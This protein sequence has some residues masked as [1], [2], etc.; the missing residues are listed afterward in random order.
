MT[1]D[2]GEALHCFF[3]MKHGYLGECIS[4]LIAI[5]SISWVMRVAL[6]TCHSLSKSIPRTEPCLKVDR[7]REFDDRSRPPIRESAGRG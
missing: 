7:R 2:I 1:V 5:V 3:M 4:E 6:R